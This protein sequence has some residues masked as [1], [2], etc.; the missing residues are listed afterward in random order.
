MLGNRI[1]KEALS[2]TKCRRFCVGQ[3]L[4]EPQSPTAFNERFATGSITINYEQQ[5]STE[6][7]RVLNLVRDQ[8]VGGS[9]FRRNG[10]V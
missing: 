8:E 3:S 2:L 1:A 7:N 5:N 6:F 4:K 10:G 9:N